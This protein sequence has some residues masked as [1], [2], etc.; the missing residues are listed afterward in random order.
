MEGWITDDGLMTEREEPATD[1]LAELFGEDSK[2]AFDQL[3]DILGGDE[4]VEDGD[5]DML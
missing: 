2:D 1:M 3:M 5:E 4:D